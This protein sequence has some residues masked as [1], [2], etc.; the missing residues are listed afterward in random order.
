MGAFGIYIIDPTAR[1]SNLCNAARRGRTG[2]RGRRVNPGTNHQP[3]RLAVTGRQILPFLSCKQRVLTRFLI[4]KQPPTCEKS[5]LSRA[6]DLPCRANLPLITPAPSASLLQQRTP[7]KNTDKFGEQSQKKSLWPRHPS[8]IGTAPRPSR[9]PPTTTA[10]NPPF[11][12]P[13][14][15]PRVSQQS[16]SREFLLRVEKRWQTIYSDAY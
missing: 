16:N 4:H 6:H 12:Q 11:L 15:A 3:D 10:S 1:R 2:R 13:S 8:W 7:R 9:T 14:S 5:F